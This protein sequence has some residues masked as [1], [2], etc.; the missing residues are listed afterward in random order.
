MRRRP[1]S[2]CNPGLQFVHLAFGVVSTLLSI[3]LRNRCLCQFCGQQLDAMLQRTPAS[4]QLSLS[5]KNI[6][7]D[8]TAVV[9]LRLEL[10]KLSLHLLLRHLRLFAGLQTLAYNDSQSLHPTLDAPHQELNDTPALDALSGELLPKLRQYIHAHCPLMCHC[11]N[12][13]LGP[14]NSSCASIGPRALVGYHSGQPGQQT[15]GP[16][17]H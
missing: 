2:S 3:V 10:S 16:C 4:A 8:L 5:N 6:I 7:V 1:C 15:V 12:R 17:S 11:R 9:P 13:R 14:V